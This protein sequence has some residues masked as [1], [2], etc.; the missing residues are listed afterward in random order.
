MRFLSTGLPI[1]QKYIHSAKFGWWQ[2]QNP[3]EYKHFII[4]GYHIKLRIFPISL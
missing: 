1:Y 4:E 2:A 3:K